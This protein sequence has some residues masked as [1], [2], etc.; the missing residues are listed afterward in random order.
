MLQ[1][2]G[3]GGGGGGCSY[4]I[5]HNNIEEQQQ[6]LMNKKAKDGGDSSSGSGSSWKKTEEASR[7]HAFAERKRRRRINDHYDS[8]RQLFPHLPKGDKATVL[9]EVVRQVKE[10]R[11]TVAN[12]ALHHEEDQCG[13][14][15]TGSSSF[16]FP[17]EN[18]EATVSY[19]NDDTEG[20]MV[21]ATVC[22]EDRPGL[23]RDLTE[24]VRSVQGRAVRAEMST[25]GGR[26]KVMVLVRWPEGGGGEEEVGGLRRALKVVVENRA[27][28]STSGLMGRVLSSSKWAGLGSNFQNGKGSRV[29]SLMGDG[30]CLTQG[31]WVK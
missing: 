14:V 7:K 19:Y 20:K 29:G 18:D 2:Q 8:L 6:Q 4:G 26:T 11:K 9:T 31:N 30:Q 1:Y 24:A 12:V 16:F 5:Q 10:L 23:N 17:G 15:T 28:G 3:G 21:K 22:C 25:I 27:L 13:G